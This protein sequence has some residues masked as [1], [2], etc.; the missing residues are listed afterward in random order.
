MYVHLS[1]TWAAMHTNTVYTGVSRVSVVAFKCET[2]NLVVSIGSL[3]RGQTKSGSLQWH[4]SNIT[5]VDCTLY[6]TGLH[7][8]WMFTLSSLYNYVLTLPGWFSLMQQKE[9]KRSGIDCIW[10]VEWGLFVT[11][12]LHINLVNHAQILSIPDY[13][14]PFIL[15]KKRD[16]AIYMW[17]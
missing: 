2:N 6:T 14:V 5:L 12:N 4:K 13:F 1:L 8:E 3:H 10:V 16:E 15:L 9:K 11:V 7:F 17:L